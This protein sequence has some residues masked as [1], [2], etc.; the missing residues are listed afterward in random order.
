MKSSNQLD[1]DIDVAACGLGV[2]TRLVRFVHQGLRDFDVVTI[3]PPP[4]V[5]AAGSS[6][7][8][9]TQFYT[10][11]KTRLSPNGILQQWFP[12]GEGPEAQAIGRSLERSFP[13]VKVYQSMWGDASYH[14]LASTSPIPDRNAQ[15]LL[16]R[17]PA[18]A[19][20]DMMEWGPAKTPEDQLDLLLL[21]QVMPRSLIALSPH[22]PALQDDR[23]INEYN[24]LRKM[25]P[26]IA[27]AGSRR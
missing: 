5:E 4:P 6:L 23:P 24:R 13:Y 1:R 9:S 14:F 21:R 18:A 12:G 26:S 8:Y 27:D 17:M 19:V 22:T 7:L 20:A 16:A 15:Q 3:D 25:F 2:R 10:L 11:L